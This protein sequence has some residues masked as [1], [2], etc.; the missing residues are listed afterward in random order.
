LR[1]WLRHD[2]RDMLQETLS[3]VSVARRGIFEPTAV[4]RLIVASESGKVDGSYT[5]FSL[6]CIELWCRLFVDGTLPDVGADMRCVSVAP[7]QS[8]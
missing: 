2:L 1:K 5:L 7:G 3:P 4:Q 8:L 6:M